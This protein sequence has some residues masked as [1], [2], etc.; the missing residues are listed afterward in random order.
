MVIKVLGSFGTATRKNWFKFG[1]DR[2]NIL[3]SEAA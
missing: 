2:V 3:D 1:H